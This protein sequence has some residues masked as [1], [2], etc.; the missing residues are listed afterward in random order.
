MDHVWTDPQLIA[1][2]MI[3]SYQDP[4]YGEVASIGNPIHLEDSPVTVRRPPPELGSDNEY[5]LT[6]LLG[7]GAETIADLGEAEA[8]WG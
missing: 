5:V 8:L 3:V 6:E 1:R 4:R 7:Y 2:D